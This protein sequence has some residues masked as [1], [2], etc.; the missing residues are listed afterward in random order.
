MCHQ[1]GDSKSNLGRCHIISTGR[2]EA[3]SGPGVLSSNCP[4]GPIRSWPRRGITTR[5]AR[6]AIQGSAMEIFTA[7]T[8]RLAPGVLAR[9]SGDRAI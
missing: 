3:N 9:R 4:R 1:G 5:I 8:D 6:Q 2:A 7:R